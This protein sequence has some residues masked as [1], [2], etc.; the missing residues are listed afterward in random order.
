MTREECIAL[1]IRYAEYDGMG[2][3]N[4]AGCKE[5]MRM[6]AELL[7]R[8]QPSLPSSL[9]EAAEEYAYKNWETDDYH[10][11]ASDGLPF[12]AIGYTVK[13]FKA[14]AKCMAGQGVSFDT[15]MSWLDSFG[16]QIGWPEDTSIFDCFNPGDKVVVQIRKK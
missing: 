12:D 1:L 11:G 15:E 16:F 10:E 14:G 9:D 8:P 5:A 7:S 4:L 2:I 3:P 13:C 6:A